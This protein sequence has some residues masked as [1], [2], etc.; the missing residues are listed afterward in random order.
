MMTRRDGSERDSERENE[1]EF[2]LEEITYPP[3]KPLHRIAL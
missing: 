3:Y 1:S 2:T